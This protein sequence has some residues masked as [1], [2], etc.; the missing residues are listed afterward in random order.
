MA[1]RD[2]TEAAHAR[3]EALSRELAA[4]DAELEALRAQ[5]RNAAEAGEGPG[6]PANPRDDGDPNDLNRATEALQKLKRRKR[7]HEEDVRERQRLERSHALMEIEKRQLESVSRW[8]NLDL[9]DIAPVLFAPTFLLTLA[10]ATL[11]NPLVY[12]TPILAIVGLI[13]SKYGG[14]AW[15][16][17]QWDRERQWAAT[18]PFE[19]T[20]YLDGLGKQPG[21]RHMTLIRLDETSHRVL[22]VRIEFERDEIPEELPEVASG[23]DP[24][25]TTQHPLADHPLYRLHS[26]RSVHK[27]SSLG[28]SEN[29][30]S[31]PNVFYRASPLSG[32]S[33]SI[34]VENHN[35]AVRDWVHRFVDELLRPLHAKYR[36]E[37]VEIRLR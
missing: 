3:A 11:W 15:A 34:S 37:R 24:E 23:F 8:A 14:Q 6:G 18:L 17:R 12:V 26:G 4:R 28:A 31:R 25:L 29:V 21:S 20:G 2:E 13:A 30:E 36:I 9:T 5:L 32:K 22:M 33:G 16:R 7:S 10:L 19:L 27:R 35:R 1:F